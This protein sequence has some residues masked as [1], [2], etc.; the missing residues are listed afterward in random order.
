[1]CVCPSDGVRECVWAMVCIC[2]SK[3]VSSDCVSLSDYVRE[4]ASESV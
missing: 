2:A 3:F 1:M 4:C